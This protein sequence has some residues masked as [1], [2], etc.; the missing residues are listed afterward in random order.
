MSTPSQCSPWTCELLGPYVFMK[1]ECQIK[2][3]RTGTDSQF[4]VNF[5][6][7]LRDWHAGLFD[8][9]AVMTQNASN[10]IGT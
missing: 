10:N 5:F 2:S 8:P 4:L 9:A 7:S 3:Q 6:L 1:D